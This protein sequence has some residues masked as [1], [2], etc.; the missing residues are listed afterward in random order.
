MKKILKCS[1]CGE[2]LKDSQMVLLKNIPESAQG[3]LKEQ[4]KISKNYSSYLVQCNYCKHVQLN[5]KPVEYYKKVIRSVGVSAEMVNYR[6]KQFEDIRKKYFGNSKKI[7][8]LE[9]GSATGE[10]SEILLNTFDQV[11]AT[12]KGA[13][14]IKSNLEKGIDCINTHPDDFDFIEKLNKLG[15]FD[16][17]CCFSYLEHLPNPKNTLNLLNNLLNNNGFYLIELPNSEMIFRRGLLNEIIPDH[18]SYFTVNTATSLMMNSGI[19]VINASCNWDNYIISLICRKTIENPI[20]KINHD[21]QLFKKR[22]DLLFNKEIY[23][24]QNIVIWGAGH[25]SL[26]TI[27]TTIFGKIASYIVDSSTTKQGL[28]A[29]GSGLKIYSPDRLKTHTPDVLI[30]ACAGYNKEVLNT[31]KNM[32]LTINC[33]YLLDGIDLIKV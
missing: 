8:V 20:Q 21:Y 26:F 10:Y 6:K 9:V 24:H 1:L 23:L 17:I 3:F 7:K 16:L 29:P 5:S 25:Q 19:E 15:K 27:S 32:K 14:N 33:I 4:D 30:I 18:L 2:P 31:V 22:L 28:Y 13:Q 11:V 12:E